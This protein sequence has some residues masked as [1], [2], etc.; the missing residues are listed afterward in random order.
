MGLKELLGI[1]ASNLSDVEIMNKIVDA[2]KNKLEVIEFLSG[3]KKVCINLIKLSPEGLMK[4]Y[5][6]YYA[7]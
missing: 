2:R 4:D 1:E 7:K 6:S 3:E 5:E